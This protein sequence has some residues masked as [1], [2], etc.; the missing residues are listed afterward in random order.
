MVFEAEPV[1]IATIQC[2]L[3]QNVMKGQILYGEQS[4]TG[5][6]YETKSTKNQI[7]IAFT[8]KSLEAIRMAGNATDI[9]FLGVAI[10]SGYKDTFIA[11]QVYGM[12]QI[13]VETCLYTPLEEHLLH[14]RGR[15]HCP[16]KDGRII[17]MDQANN[18]IADIQMAKEYSHDG[19]SQAAKIVHCL[20]I[21]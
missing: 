21:A 11:L 8:D 13:I 10:T 15:I 16:H 19:T 5:L 14:K 1:V 3:K 17:C 9:F 18:R 7:P 4:R 20:I 12:T 6:V 2:K